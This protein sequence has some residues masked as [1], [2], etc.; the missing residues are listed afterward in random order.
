[1]GIV[2]VPIQPVYVF[3]LEHLTHLH[4]IIDIYVPI[5]ISLIVWGLFL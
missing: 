4:L 1:M 2:L 3:W 5:A